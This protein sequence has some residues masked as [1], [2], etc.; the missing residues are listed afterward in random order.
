M[1]FS[2]EVKEE[3]SHLSCQEEHCLKAELA[4]IICLCSDITRF[5]RENTV[6][7][8]GQRTRLWQEGFIL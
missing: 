8:C 6:W 1:S 3:L 4:A 2:S 7:T 5:A